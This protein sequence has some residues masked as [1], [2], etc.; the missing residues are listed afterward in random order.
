M[1]KNN[2][3]P[4]AVMLLFTG[5]LYAQ[6]GLIGD[7]YDGPEFNRKVLTR[8]DHDLDFDWEQGV[9]P[10]PGL[11][12][13]QFSVRWTGR[14]LAPETGNYIF[15]SK[16]DDGIRLWIGDKQVIDAWGPHDSESFTGSIDLV[17]GRS[18][19]LKVEYFNGILEGEIHLNWE[20]PS[21][22][23]T[24]KGLFGN[25]DKKIDPKYYL[26]PEQ[27]KVNQKPVAAAPKPVIKKPVPKPQKTPATNQTALA[28]TIQKYIPKNIL[29]EQSQPIMLPGSFEELN[30][31]A[32]MLS[33]YP[34]LH[35]SVEGHTDNIGDPV[36]NQKLSEERAKAVAAY[37]IQKGI[38]PERV[39]S[40]GHGS[41]RPLTNENTPDGHARNRRVEFVIK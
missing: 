27:P 39:S 24:F 13:S 5:T 36:K 21:E 1:D 14:I 37:L 9:S 17:G 40:E 26:L 34:A 33:R 7:Y 22:K 19:D 35:V 30:L 8:T 20:L 12:P 6:Q 23:P 29:F 2:L 28:D 38:A 25:N 18:Y 3:L 32:G 16:V 4:L 41:S 31:L 11:P 15:F 10:G